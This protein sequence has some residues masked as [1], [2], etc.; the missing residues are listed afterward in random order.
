MLIEPRSVQQVA[1]LPFIAL[2]SGIEVLL[3]TSRRR[4][5][6]IVPKGWPQ[7]Q[8]TLSAA[9]AREA[10]EEA[11]V[12]GPVQ[13]EPV[14]TYSY[15]KEMRAGYPVLCHVFVYP[16]VVRQHLL[17]WRE[18]SQRK[19]RWSGLARAAELVDDEDLALLL[20]TLAREDGRPLR[21]FA[22]SAVEETSGA[23]TTA[24]VTAASN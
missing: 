19:L 3:I 23:D 6:W 20:R 24:T 1:T 10:F 12:L 14:G 4:Q 17:D 11:G 2:P 16:L 22:E 8:R 21:R 7:K 18:R 13:A 15:D 9:A 5:R